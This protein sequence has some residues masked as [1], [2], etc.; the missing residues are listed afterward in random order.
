M[1][2]DNT[3]RFCKENYEVYLISEEIKMV[4]MYVA[5]KRRNFHRGYNT[6]RHWTDPNKGEYED[7]YWGVLGEIVFRDQ[8]NKRKLKSIFN[9]PPLFTEN[10]STIPK[11]DAKVN[12]KTVEI[13]SIPP[14]SHGMRRIRLM[15]KESEF[16]KDDYFVPIKFW[17]DNSYSF[18]GY[19]TLP[20]V[21][22]S[23]IQTLKY[24][25]G[26]SFLLETIPNHMSVLWDEWEKSIFI[27]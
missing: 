18:C 2:S 6:K 16:H 8:I 11:W 26:Y 15:I 7:E 21:L 22:N 5:K 23:P 27:N 25:K 12:D 3:L 1:L 17:D 20:E 13:K 10:Q 19:L 4:S 24:S 9:F 14:D